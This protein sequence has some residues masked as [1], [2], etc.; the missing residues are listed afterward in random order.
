[1][2]RL[3]KIITKEILEKLLIKEGLEVRVA[4]ER[5]GLSKDAVLAQM[6]KFHV[7]TGRMRGGRKAEIRQSI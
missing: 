7:R 6:K 2:R 5:L 3:G 1:M 4:G